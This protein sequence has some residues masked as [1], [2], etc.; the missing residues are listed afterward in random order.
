M[1]WENIFCLIQDK[2]LGLYQQNCPVV[3]PN[4]GND[5]SMSRSTTN[6]IPNSSFTS[7]FTSSSN[8]SSSSSMMKQAPL[9]PDDKIAIEDIYENLD[10]FKMWK[11][12]SGTIVEK[13]M[14]N[15]AL[16]C[17]FEQ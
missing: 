5:E 9:T 15:F 10:P 16:A 17:T 11:L 14:E 2:N 6:N 3:L 4:I 12:S 7:N 13:E 8:S 1:N